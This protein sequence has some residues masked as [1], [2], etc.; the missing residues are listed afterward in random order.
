MPASSATISAT[1]ATSIHA[2]PA[3]QTADV[4]SFSAAA[5]ALSPAVTVAAATCT[6]AIRAAE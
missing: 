5:F 3:S 2:F 6:S 1:S 4:A